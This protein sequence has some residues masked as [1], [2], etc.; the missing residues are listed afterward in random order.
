ML[1]KR[2][3]DNKDLSVLLQAI[4]LN[5]RICRWDSDK[6]GYIEVTSSIYPDLKYSVNMWDYAKEEKLFLYIIKDEDSGNTLYVTR[7]YEVAKKVKEKIQ[8]DLPTTLLDI[9]TILPQYPDYSF[10]RSID[11]KKSY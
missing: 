10:I 6:T 2:V 8:K 11:V 7:D 3:T 5:E 4:P 1:K 9:D